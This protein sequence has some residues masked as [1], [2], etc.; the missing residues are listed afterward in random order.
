M[1]YIPLPHPAFTVI[2]A[3]FVTIEDGTGIVHM[4]QAFG[5]DD[6][7]ATR[8][9]GIPGIYVKDELGDDVPIVDKHGRFVDEITDFAGMYVKNYDDSDE[10]DPNY[11]PIC[12]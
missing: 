3:D 11:R 12:G 5:A 6:F 2:G 9:M 7:K 10:S 4:A 1:P 8:E